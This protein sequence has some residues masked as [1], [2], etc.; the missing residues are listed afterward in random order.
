MELKQPQMSVEQFISESDHE[1][2]LPGKHTPAATTT[3]LTVEPKETGSKEEQKKSHTSFSNE[4]HFSPSDPDSRLSKMTGKPL[5]MNHLS[6]PA[7]V[8]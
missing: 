7:R 4:T 3:P 8:G 1:N 5:H 6:G 2:T